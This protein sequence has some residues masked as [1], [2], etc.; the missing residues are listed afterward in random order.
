MCSDLVREAEFKSGPRWNFKS[1]NRG[2]LLRSG[3]PSSTGYSA[4]TLQLPALESF[5]LETKAAMFGK[6]KTF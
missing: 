6:V 1:K 4:A 3:S 2:S 5:I